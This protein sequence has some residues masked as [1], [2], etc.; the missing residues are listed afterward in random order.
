MVSVGRVGVKHDVAC[1][2]P[3]SCGV[4][5]GDWPRNEV[6]DGGGMEKDEKLPI[7]PRSVR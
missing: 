6:C 4:A 1:H 5:M 2:R 3:G 7:F